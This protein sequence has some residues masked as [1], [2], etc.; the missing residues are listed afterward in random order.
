[1]QR[2]RDARIASHTGDQIDLV[3]TGE[4]VDVRALVPVRNRHGTLSDEGVESCD[5]GE[6]AIRAP[7][8]DVLTVD[9]AGGERVVRIQH[10]LGPLAEVVEL[11]IE[12]AYLPPQREYEL[13]RRFE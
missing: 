4:V 13:R 2:H 3:L 12:M 10:H 5:T 6:L 8:H 11:R 1:M 7:H 9:D